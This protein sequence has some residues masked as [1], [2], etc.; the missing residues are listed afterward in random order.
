M[1]VDLGAILGTSKVL[2][3]SRRSR[4][5]SGGAEERRLRRMSNT[6]Q[7]ELAKSRRFLS[8]RE[9]IDGNAA[10]DAL[11]GDQGGRQRLRMVIGG[12]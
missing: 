10:D 4:T 5:L 7:V 1:A 12:S 2:D 11:M 8:G 3:A 9:T 6:T